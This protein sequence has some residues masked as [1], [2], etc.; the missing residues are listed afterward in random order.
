MS[1]LD[2]DPDPDPDRPSSLFAE[3]RRRRV[4]RVT[5]TYVLVAWILMQAGEIVFPA[6]ELPNSAL[7]FRQFGRQ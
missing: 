4:F 6:F 5:G 7:R 1:S 2:P 3:I